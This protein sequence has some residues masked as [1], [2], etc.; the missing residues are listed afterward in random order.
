MSLSGRVAAITGASSGIGLA[1]A[2]HL[3]REGV[4]VVLGARR[5]PLLEA[6]A[7]RIRAAGGRAAVA[8][9]DVECESDVRALVET[10]IREF[11]RLDV[12]ICNAG[13]GYYAP[14]DETPPAVMRRM[15]DV[16]YMGTFYGAAAALP[17]FR[18]QQ[19]GHLIFIS[20]I[21]GRRGIPEMGG[22]A[23]TK[24][25]QAGLAESLRAEFAGTPIHVSCVYPVSTRT[26]FTDAM[27]RDYGYRISGLGP[28]QSVDVVAAA[29]VGC[30]RRPRPEVYPH[31]MSRGLTLLNALAPGLTDRFVR[32]YGRRRNA[33]PGDTTSG[34]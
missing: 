8:R 11:G 10:A 4:A 25:A 12:M 30:V 5:V 23:A 14:I 6:T 28:K 17:V 33:L 22:Y 24:A 20:S 19:S 18:R 29:I 21:V 34:E 1:C 7:D 31:R 16:N 27:A 3:A 13:F 15:I 32:K 2:T 26:E 9:V